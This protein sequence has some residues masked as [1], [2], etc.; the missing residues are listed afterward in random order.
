MRKG[1]YILFRCLKRMP[2]L[3]EVETIRRQLEQQF[4]GR[5]IQEIRLFQY[6]QRVDGSLRQGC[7]TITAVRRRGK[8]LIME[9]DT[10][11]SLLFHLKMSGQMI[12]QEE[13]ARTPHTRV[14]LRFP[15]GWMLFNDTRKFGF[16]KV[17]PTPSLQHFFSSYGPEPLEM[18]FSTFSQQLQ[19]KKNSTL[20][21]T[22]LDQTVIA[23]LGNIYAQEACFLAGIDGRRK[24]ST[25]TSGEL[26]RLYH[27]IQR[28][29]QR[30]LR[31]RG[32]STD[33]F[34][35]DLYGKAGQF[36]Q[37]LSVYGQTNCHTCHHEIVKIKLGGRGT[38][39]CPR[40]QK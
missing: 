19:R 40:C 2:E 31:Y 25:L 27:N 26:K 13:L 29:L 1:L 39:Y 33:A 11:Y 32:T 7:G 5:P 23:G 12:W 8:V 28:V 4:T 36:A 21:P 6:R 35:I 3:P 24:I 17:V 20:K 15:Q 14:T 16:M 34:Y 9:V 38:Y 30:S 37:K 18:S 22:L 10:G